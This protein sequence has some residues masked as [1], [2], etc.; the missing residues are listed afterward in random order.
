MGLILV[1][2]MDQTIIDSNDQRFFEDVNTAEEYRA[3]KKMVRD[4]LNWNIV[5]IM[6]RASKLRP[7]KVSAMCLLT[8]NSYDVL[9]SVLDEI[10]LEITGSVGKYK[11]YPGNANSNEMPKKSYFFDSIM[12]RQHRSRPMTV[13]HNPPKRYEDIMNM[14]KY[15]GVKDPQMKD[16]FFFDDVGTHALRSEFNFMSD[17]K[18][19]DHY[20]QIRP[21]FSKF[22][23]DMTFYIPVLQALALLDGKPPSLP[24]VDS[25]RINVSKGRRPRSNTL[26]ENNLA[27]NLPI[28]PQLTSIR[29]TAKIVRTPLSNVFGR[30]GG[31]RSRTMKKRNK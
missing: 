4:S 19:K 31:S 23:T 14:M 9:V 1:F 21:P 16:T 30:R 17:G 7:D 24:P 6:I 20:I 13:D 5:N 10:L 26:N 29:K 25:R 22:S 15:I 12:M 27:K 28:P 3:F 2:D 8:N 18:Y 11:T